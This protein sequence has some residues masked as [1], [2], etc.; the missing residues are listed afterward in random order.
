MRSAQKALGKFALAS[1]FIFSCTKR[2]KEISS[3]TNI[4]NHPVLVKDFT[5]SSSDILNTYLPNLSHQIKN[6]TITI[7]Y[8]SNIE[9]DS[10]ARQFIIGHLINKKQIIAL[11]INLKSDSIL[12][13]RLL[14]NYWQRI[15]KE[16]IQLP[17]IENIKFMDLDGDNSNEI[18]ATT[19]ANMNGNRWL[20]VYHYSNSTDSIKVAGF[21][22]TDYVINTSKQQLQ[23]TYEGSWYTDCSKTLYQWQHNKLIPI[24]R[25]I[26]AH[27][28]PVNE[29]S[30]LTLQYYD[31]KTSRPDGLRL[32]FQ[33]RYVDSLSRQRKL[34]DSF[35]DT[36]SD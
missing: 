12:F 16:S 5:K 26:L 10:T 19:H 28:T 22:S 6:D 29:D 21:F 4:Q 27:D 13:F 1:A 30:K 20:E 14:N 24:K 33:E 35:F 25:I 31:N 18:L 32:K 36:N 7:I 17:D 8:G 15:G 11:E 34:W 9:D 2:T 3:C 23:E